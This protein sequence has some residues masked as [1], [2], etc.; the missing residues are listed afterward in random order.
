[1]AMAN[2][3]FDNEIQPQ[4]NQAVEELGR[5]YSAMQIQVADYSAQEFVN[6]VIALSGFSGPVLIRIIWNNI[7]LTEVVRH[8]ERAM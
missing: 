3:I 1:M 4:L 2:I 8:F 5:R 6:E 7:D